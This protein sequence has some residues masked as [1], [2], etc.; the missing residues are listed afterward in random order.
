MKL[1]YPLHLDTIE[2]VLEINGEG[3]TQNGEQNVGVTYTGK[4]FFEEKGKTIFKPDGQSISLI[5]FV[6]IGADVAPNIEILSGTVKVNGGNEYT[7]Y[8]GKRSRNPDGSVLFTRLEL[9]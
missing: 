3:I 4:C 9:M 5:G 2:I 1:E 8:T 7:I 6:T